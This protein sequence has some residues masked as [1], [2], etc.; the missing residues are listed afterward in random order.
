MLVLSVEL[1]HIRG[2]MGTSRLGFLW[3][4]STLMAPTEGNLVA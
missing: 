3:A 1:L 2:R 4:S